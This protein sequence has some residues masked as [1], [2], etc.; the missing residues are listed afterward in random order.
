[1]TLSRRFQPEVLVA[2]REI[3][4]VRSLDVLQHAL[5]RKALLRYKLPQE[6]LEVH[7]IASVPGTGT[8]LGSSSALAVALVKACREWQGEPPLSWLDLASEAYELERADGGP[9]VGLQDAIAAAK[10]DANLVQLREVKRR[11]WYWEPLSPDRMAALVERLL[12]F[13]AQDRACS[14]GDIMADMAA[15]M[16]SESDELAALDLASNQALAM[17]HA[18]EEGDWAR[19]G[20]WLDQGW[21][22]KRRFSPLIAT[23]RIDALYD[24]CRQAGALGGKLCGA[25]GGGFLLLCCEP[26]HQAAVREVMGAAGCAELPVRQAQV[27]AR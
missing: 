19:V 8:G 25:G 23:E 11:S 24:L 18:I 21:Q 7:L 22:T 16:T 20:H 5:V 2:Y 1:M 3:E 6:H 17:A 14:A 10:G 12:L 13:A 15:R 27:Q 9:L 4:E 26:E